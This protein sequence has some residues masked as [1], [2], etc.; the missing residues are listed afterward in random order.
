MEQKFKEGE[1][2]KSVYF[3]ACILGIAC[4]VPAGCDADGNSINFNFLNGTAYP[5]ELELYGV[6]GIKDCRGWSAK[7]SPR[8][9]AV[10]T[11]IPAGKNVLWT[12]PYN[13]T[14]N[15]SRGQTST[16]YQSTPPTS[17]RV[18]IPAL[19]KPIFTDGKVTGQTV[20]RPAY[21]VDSTVVNTKEGTTFAIMADP[22]LT[23]LNDVQIISG[24]RIGKWIY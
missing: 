11:S 16:N 4:A 24:L 17:I 23:F 8:K 18:T 13:V 9:C 20:E 19:I 2:M 12:V 21:S 3:Y 10:P 7:D 1:T 15:V 14:K 6:S 5:V 22:R